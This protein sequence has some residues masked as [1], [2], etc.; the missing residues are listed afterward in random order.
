MNV[1]SSITKIRRLVGDI[2]T[3]VFSDA[4]IVGSFA[5]IQQEFCRKTECEAEVIALLKPPR[6]DYCMTQLWEEGFV[7]YR[8]FDPFFKGASHAA[9]QAWE[10]E[11]EYTQES[12]GGYT[13]T[14]GTELSHVDLQHE[15]PFLM[16]KD[17]YRFKGLL[18]D[19]KWIQ[20]KDINWVYDYYNDAFMK[21]GDQVDWFAPIKRG[22]GKAFVTHA[23]PYELA[24]IVKPGDVT[25]PDSETADQ[26]VSYTSAVGID[27]YAWSKIFNYFSRTA[28]NITLGF[29][30]F[31][32]DYN[33]GIAIRTVT[34]PDLGDG[35]V[36][37][38]VAVIAR[39][40]ASAGAANDDCNLKCYF[41]D[42]DVPNVPTSKNEAEALSLTTGVD[43]DAVEEFVS[44]DYDSPDL[45]VALLEVVGRDGWESGDDLHLVIKN[46]SSDVSATRAV[47]SYESGSG[48]SPNRMRLIIT[49]VSTPVI[50]TE[51]TAQNV[52]HGQGAIFY[53][54]ATGWSLT[55]QWRKNGVNISGATSASYLIEET[56]ADHEGDYDCI[57]SNG[58]GTLISDLVTLVVLPEDRS[59]AIDVDLHEDVFYA[60]YVAVPDRP[61]TTS[62][63]VETHEPFIK[64]LEY[65][66]AA[67]LL[68]ADTKKKDLLKAVHFNARY[69]I[70]AQL[71][72]HI[73]RKLFINR[74]VGLEPSRRADIKPSR[75]RLP[76]HYPRLEA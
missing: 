66:V 76:D 33:G 67:K 61:T 52:I 28:T 69:E 36:P 70:G 75:P 53:L 16:S 11:Y 57:V 56:S 5:R 54:V 43:W 48:A 18:F 7:T 4:Q 29:N 58:A 55:F 35:V 2:N 1:S 13:A 72:G 26:I 15:V 14:G 63:E 42:V 65:G 50:T 40:G 46:N 24:A 20:E 37:V 60:A 10:L 74:K 49:F 9:T 32:R 39:V 8:V 71:V 22:H 34:Y 27:D 38:P 31:S 44:G 12:I 6:V 21:R 45:L 17:F 23:V 30:Q 62:D 47:S 68:R 3:Q 51:P 41:E 19:Y 59:S 73:M 25:V 64:Y